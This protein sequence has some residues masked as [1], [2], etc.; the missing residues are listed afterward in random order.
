MN[1]FGDN[2]T[3]LFFAVVAN[4][5]YQ[6]QIPAVTGGV[7]GGEGADVI[8]GVEFA[9]SD[10]KRRNIFNVLNIFLLIDLT[11]FVFRREVAVAKNA[12]CFD[13]RP[14]MCLSL[15][16]IHERRENKEKKLDLEGF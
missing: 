9:S 8:F 3:V 16:I 7:R 11:P 4:L 14:E 5:E 10:E 13:R 12:F 2:K 15:R 1:V 6:F